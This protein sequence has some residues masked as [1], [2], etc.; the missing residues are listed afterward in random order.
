[1]HVGVYTCVYVCIELIVGNYLLGVN[2][3][4]S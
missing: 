4:Y 2:Y 3:E 1:V